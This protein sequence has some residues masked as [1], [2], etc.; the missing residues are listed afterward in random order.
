MSEVFTSAYWTGI[1]DDAAKLL[2]GVGLRVITILVLFWVVRNTLIRLTRLALGQ[3]IARQGRGTAEDQRN[4]LQ[5]LQSVLESVIGYILLF[6]LVVTLLQALSINVTGI[7]T[8]AGVGGVALGFGAQRIVRDILAG[9][10][11]IMEDQYAVGDYVSIGY[12]NILPVGMVTG[13]VEELTMRV[14]RVRDD[15]GRLWVL[16]NGDIGAVAN[17]SRSPVETFLDI[18]VPTTLGVDEARQVLVDTLATEFTER[19]GALVSLPE[20]RGVV[21][22]DG[23]SSTLRIAYTADPRVAQ[24]EAL[25][26]REVAAHSLR[27]AATQASDR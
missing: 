5:T 7:L 22:F 23:T 6:V 18:G 13:V 12:P 2:P 24:L 8:T 20:V 1:W 17:H 26:L 21:A 19:P 15:T 11:I 25:R 3:I 14:T 4:R 9:Y 10:F 27:Q 16:A